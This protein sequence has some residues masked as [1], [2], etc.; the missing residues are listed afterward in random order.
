MELCRYRLSYVIALLHS[1]L[2]LVIKL[3]ARNPADATS[4]PASSTGVGNSTE[5]GKSLDN[6]R[7]QMFIAQMIAGCLAWHWTVQQPT[8][9]DEQGAP[10]PTTS[11]LLVEDPPPLDDRTAKQLLGAVSFF[12][13]QSTMHLSATSGLESASLSPP[14]HSPPTPYSPAQS[15]H[16]SSH[17]GS[18]A[19][20]RKRASPSLAHS[21]LVISSES[22]S[23]RYSPSMQQDA[24]SVVN[25]ILS[26]AA[27]ITGYLSASRWDIMLAKLR[28]RIPYYSTEEY[29]D[30]SEVRLFEFCAL[31]DNR[32]AALL[33]EFS[34]F[35]HLKRS[36]QNAM[37][38]VLRGAIWH[39]ITAYPYAFADLYN[40]SK[41]LPIVGQGQPENLLDM[42]SSLPGTSIAQK[43]AIWQTQAA[44]L[45]LCP[46]IVAKL[47]A[48]TGE[49]ANAGGLAALARQGSVTKKLQ[50]L[51]TLRK[52]VRSTKGGSAAA[53]S[54]EERNVALACY[55]D[56][57][58]AAT[59]T[60]VTETEAS[61]L[62]LF[63]LDMEKDLRVRICV[64]P[65]SNSLLRLFCITVAPFRSQ[66][67]HPDLRWS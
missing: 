25:D 53:S 27:S 7:S 34:T 38:T 37:C 1:E 33:A 17:P 36:A 63:V 40:G 26:S 45:V 5:N 35:M 65:L 8:H 59:F 61:S 15:S 44:L 56:I 39:F 52:A 6:L 10:L 14:V 11:E 31:N 58:R 2:E 47:V 12:L 50:Y 67:P 49:G 24:Q 18:P 60:E 4:P 22:I 30:L 46:D 48:H 64:P 51:D 43:G 54:N 42:L 28:N 62:R 3:P 32:L 57:C 55:A 13:K 9:L 41:R 20:S 23:T 66:P 29:P 21:S 19:G 16:Y